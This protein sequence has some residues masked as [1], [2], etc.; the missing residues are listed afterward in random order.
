MFV[1]PCSL[2][3]TAVAMTMQT[4]MKL[5]KPMPMYVSSLIRHGC[6]ETYYGCA[7]SAA[8]PGRR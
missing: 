3:V 1:V 6:S 5:E 4:A 7:R 2:S 8:A